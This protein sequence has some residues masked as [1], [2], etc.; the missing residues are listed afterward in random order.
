MAVRTVERFQN[1]TCNDII[2]LRLF[3]YNN[4]SRKDVLSIA[5]VDIYTFDQTAISELNPDGSRLVAT[6]NGTDILA[7]ET[8]QYLCQITATSP[9]YTI[10]AYKD[11]WTVTFEDN[12][13]STAEVANYFEIYPDLWF[14]T[15][16]PPVY[17][18]NFTL[19]P[20][21]IRQGSK[22]YLLIQITPNNLS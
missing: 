2:N 17:D 18:F 10:G 22:R 8:G 3:T 9:L 12:D 15:A 20:N 13:C 7:E 1:P 4:N 5:K 11:V 21:R 14:T 19:R 6:V 16:V